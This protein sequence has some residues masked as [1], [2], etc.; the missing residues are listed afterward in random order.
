MSPSGNTQ[1]MSLVAN[2]S[3]NIQYTYK[4]NPYE[5]DWQQLDL[6][7]LDQNLYISHII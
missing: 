5:N 1:L 2:V 3:R 6:K 4:K 7:A